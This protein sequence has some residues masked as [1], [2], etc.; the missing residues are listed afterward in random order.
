M[1]D[2]VETVEDR[3]ASM[4]AAFEA[5]IE[6]E[7]P[8]AEPSVEA[9]DAA[10]ALPAV[11]APPVQEPPPSPPDSESDDPALP[12]GEPVPYARF[13]KVIGQR[14]SV[15]DELKTAAERATRADALEQE[16]SWLAQA[17]PEQRQAVQYWYV[18]Q[19]NN[20]VGY[21]AQLVREL[22][23]NP[24]S[25]DQVRQELAAV[26]GQG[27]PEA[28]V[29]SDAMPQPDWRNDASGELVY[30]PAQ[31]QALE[32]WR[33]REMQ[34]ALDTRLGP[35]E[36]AEATRQQA[37]RSAQAYQQASALADS[38]ARKELAEVQTFYGWDHAWVREA[39][40]QEMLN[41]VSLTSAV[42]AYVRVL[43]RDILP[44]MGQ[45]AQAE[46]LSDLQIKAAAAQ[47]VN[48]GASSTSVS[49]ER[50]T[51]MVEALRQAGLEV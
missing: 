28:P 41:D 7:T 15:R 2:D 44:R 45:Q 24:S 14:N 49:T 8:S 22:V 12:E 4:E 20:P 51:S 50:P 37:V 30:S 13:A 3:P 9:G 34:R 40:K 39:V 35:I 10:S 23:T 27:Q 36:Q 48:P 21:A 18:Q 31:Q 38:A 19:R 32:A 1:A 33:S 17:T 11:P 6:A 5:V 43:H 46:V 25:A 47:S 16:Y 42:P 29:E 26:L